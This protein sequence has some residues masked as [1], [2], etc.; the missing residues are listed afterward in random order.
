MKTYLIREV[1]NLNSIR[2]GY[3]VNEP[4]L[5]EAQCH[6]IRNRTF[7]CTTLAIE[8]ADSELLCYLEDGEWHYEFEED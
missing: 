6:A 8:D 1:Q 4:S 7:Q 2:A 3:T 5:Y